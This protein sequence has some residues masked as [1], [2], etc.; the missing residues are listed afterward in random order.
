MEWILGA[1]AVLAGPI[2]WLI[3]SAYER[4]ERNRQAVSE[5]RLDAYMGV[6]D[7]YI[8]ILT[9]VR[10]PRETQKALRAVQ[11]VEH[12]R[13]VFRI[14]LMAPDG[15]VQAYNKLMR[16]T[17]ADSP[18]TMLLFSRLLLEVRKD[19]GNRGTALEEADMLISQLK[20]VDRDTF[21]L[22]L[23]TGGFQES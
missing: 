4:E 9:G 23:T 16:A 1:V 7:P 8:R 14:V 22:M 5:A 10:N 15:V 12:R 17:Y 2:G 21:K 11:Q 19:L 6:I 13:H 3:R 20:D 18:R